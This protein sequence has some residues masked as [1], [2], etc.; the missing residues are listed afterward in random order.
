[1]SALLCAIICSTN[2]GTKAEGQYGSFL[3]LFWLL[4][5]GKWM[6]SETET[7]SQC[8]SEPDSPQWSVC[9]CTSIC[10]CACVQS[11]TWPLFIS[12]SGS[13]RSVAKTLFHHCCSTRHVQTSS[14]LVLHNQE[15]T[16]PP[17]SSVTWTFTL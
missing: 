8:E 12:G 16:P 17:M 15:P 2:S 3:S 5:S 1:M 11:P 10:L 9:T 6:H 14:S 13:R 7:S 4:Q